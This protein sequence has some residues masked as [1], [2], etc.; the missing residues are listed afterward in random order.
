M[1]NYL[2]S[3]FRSLQRS[4]QTMHLVPNLSDLSDV[5]KVLDREEIGSVPEDIE[6]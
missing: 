2:R 4:A 6:E 1:L 5:E 3:G